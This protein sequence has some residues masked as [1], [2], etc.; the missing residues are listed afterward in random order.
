MAGV[1]AVFTN[2]TLWSELRNKAPL[3]QGIV[4]HPY[5][6]HVQ[7]GCGY[8]YHCKTH[9]TGQGYDQIGHT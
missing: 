1:T 6:H 5:P 8:E 3:G 7:G 4:Q 2:R 9:H